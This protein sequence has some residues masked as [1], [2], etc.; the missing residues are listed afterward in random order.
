MIV[1]DA[2]MVDARHYTLVQ[3]HRMYN[4]KDSTVNY[5][6]WMITVCQ[7]R[8]MG[9]HRGTTLVWD[10][11]S[12]EGCECVKTGSVGSLCTCHLSLL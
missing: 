8:L 1:Y 4:T 6:L 7:Y 10:V 12:G 2:I 3:S 5:G 9:D 11:D